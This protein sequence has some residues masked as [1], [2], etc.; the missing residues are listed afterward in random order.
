MRIA[1]LV[2]AIV[3]DNNDTGNLGRV[4]VSFPWLGPTYQSDWIR[5][6]QLGA[7][8]KGGSVWLPE[9]KDEVLVGFEFGDFRR[10]YVVCGLYNKSD[11]DRVSMSG[12]VT[13]GAA[14]WRGFVSRQGHKI[15]FLEELNNHGVS[16]TTKDEKITVHLD[17]STP[18]QEKVTIEI[19]GSSGGSLITADAMGA[20]S[21][22]AKG[23]TGS[24]TLKGTDITIEATK[25]L[26]MKGNLV[27]LE[28]T[29]SAAIKGK[30]IQLN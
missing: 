8:I 23:A 7:G 4:K 22:E 13:L 26:T 19:K 17:S 15:A 18:N 2:P 6:G 3:M 27:N 1:G 5:V 24:I 14:K 30:P 21:I 20:I 16:I 10:P 11:S 28:A 9:P 29:T 12:M 25:Q